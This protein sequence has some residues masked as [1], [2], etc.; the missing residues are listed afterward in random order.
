MLLIALMLF[1]LGVSASFVATLLPLAP[2]PHPA[3]TPP[4][5]AE[6]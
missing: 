4:T 1:V 3:Q 5:E 6:V 2:A